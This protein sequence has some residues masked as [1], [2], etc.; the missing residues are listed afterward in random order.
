MNYKD[1]D[2]RK[3]IRFAWVAKKQIF[4]I[5]KIEREKFC[6]YGFL[7][8]IKKKIGSRVCTYTW[9]MNWK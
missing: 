9:N 6:M 2:E 4:F 7:F 8:L 3:N 5:H 1:K